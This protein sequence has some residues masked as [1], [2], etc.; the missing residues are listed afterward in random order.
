MHN[1]Q[2]ACGEVRTKTGQRD[3]RA[4]RLALVVAHTVLQSGNASGWRRTAVRARREADGHREQLLANRTA[5]RLI[6]FALLRLGPSVRLVIV[7]VPGVHPE[8][9]PGRPR[10]DHTVSTLPGLAA[11]CAGRSGGARIF[12]ALPRSAA[13]T[14]CI[15]RLSRPSRLPSLSDVSRILTR[16]RRLSSIHRYC[17]RNRDSLPSS[18]RSPPRP[19]RLRPAAS[20]PRAPRDTPPRARTTRAAARPSARRACPS[21]RA[22]PRRP[23]PPRLFSSRRA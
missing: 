6:E 20:T 2:T 23:P 3:A 9:H 17:E 7:E 5:H 13:T 21:P 11:A 18:T 8:H 1:E 14:V 10:V 12:D 15:S 22:S 4:V 19:L 16:A